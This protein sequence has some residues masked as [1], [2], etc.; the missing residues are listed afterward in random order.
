MNR[1]APSARMKA[2]EMPPV[3]DIMSRITEL[4]DSGRDVISMAQAVP[5]YGPPVDTLRKFTGLIADPALH[6]YSPDPGF[7]SAR[8]AV[9]EDFR[10]RRNISLDPE[11]ELHLTCGA[12]QAFLSALLAC[13]SSGE[14]VAVLEPYY[15][16]H[17][18]AVQFSGLELVSIPLDESEGR[19]LVPMD[20][21]E[22]TM[23]T[24]ATLVLVNPGNPTGMVIPDG[25]M[26]EITEMARD[27][28]T[29]L[30]ID[31]TYERFVFT[32]DNWHPRQD[33]TAEHVLTLGSFSKSLGMPGWRIG[34]LF[35]AGEMLEQAIKVQDSV[36]ICPPA[37]SQKLLELTIRRTG[38]IE[39][40]SAEVKRRR[41]ICKKTLLNGSGGL[42]WREAGGAFF[43][44]AQLETGM[45]SYQ[46]ALHLLEEYGIGTIPGSAFGES[47][48]GHLRISFGCL[49]ESQIETAMEKLAEASFPG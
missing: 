31:E 20:R 25:T 4:R 44:L 45:N 11:C 32:G 3:A 29:F 13:T 46:A 26:K 40:M 23:K 5:W 41:D 24:A 8:K 2:V 47:G 22:E 9:A 18:F 42:K 48:E 14:K 35:G 17:I 37:P 15:F 1:F 6:R 30:I 16:D 27:T 34:Y 36:V 12:S 21:L 38:W 49:K 19:W 7:L 33:S 39:K 43:T 10:S 28:G